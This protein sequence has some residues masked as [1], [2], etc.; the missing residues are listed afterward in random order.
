MGRSMLRLAAVLALGCGVAERATPRNATH[1]LPASETA[2]AAAAVASWS[3]ESAHGRVGGL[4]SLLFND[5][6][7]IRSRVRRRA[8]FD[9]SGRDRGP[10]NGD[11]LALN[12][13]P[14]VP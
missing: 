3:L 13:R 7:S 14:R 1:R 9:L 12:V 11:R 8:L 6:P 10:A 2:S 5:S 4:E